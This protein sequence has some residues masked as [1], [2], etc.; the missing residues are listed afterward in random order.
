MRADALF[1]I[2]MLFFLFVAWVATGGPSRPIA[3]AGPYITPVSRTGEESQGYR[4]SAPTNPIN[5]ASYPKQING[6][7]A[8]PYKDNYY[9]YERTGTSGTGASGG[10]SNTQGTATT[11]QPGVRSISI[12]RSSVGPTSAN[13]NQ[14]YVALSVSGGSTV[15][16]TGY[17][18]VS[19]KTHGSA[20]IQGGTELA[21]A[22]SV[23]P[24]N[25]V[26]LRPGD[27][28]LVT[29]GSS[30]I[31]TSFR[32][33]ACTGYLG[34]FQSFYPPIIKN[35]PL[36]TTEV[37][38]AYSGSDKGSC[39]SFSSRISQCSTLVSGSGMGSPSCMNFLQSTLSYNACTDAHR[40][41][42]GFA[43]SNWR[44]YLGQGSE[45]WANDHDTIT[46]TDPSG[47]EV[48]SFTY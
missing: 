43:S 24:S 45:L 34:Q 22:G 31:G 42:P 25:A 30:P 28:M 44:M 29:T 39:A 36:P 38:R 27:H 15:S 40:Q 21:R 11:I 9:S 23:N 1:V 26:V 13:P 19:T 16:L 12:D 17:R 37:M 47:K 4:V 48:D 3:T 41:D 18:L 32:E 6:A 33:N 2:T 14:E 7:S 5:G 20:T 35:C 46:L 10:T 8:S